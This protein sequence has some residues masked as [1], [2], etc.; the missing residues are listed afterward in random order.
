[1]NP[2]SAGC[3]PTSPS[4]FAAAIFLDA[5]GRGAVRMLA[6]RGEAIQG[7]TDPEVLRCSPPPR[8]FIVQAAR[9]QRKWGG[10]CHGG[11]TT[12]PLPKAGL[13]L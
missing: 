1:M 11:L 5:D 2:Q 9:E 10:G 6:G 8:S 7:Q 12:A 4:R 3:L 13:D